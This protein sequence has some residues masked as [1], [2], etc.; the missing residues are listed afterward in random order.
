MR[1]ALLAALAAPALLAA[2]PVPGYFRPDPLPVLHG[3]KL[4][5]VTLPGHGTVVAIAPDA[6]AIAIGGWTPSKEPLTETHW[7]KVYGID[8]KERFTAD[9]QKRA[10]TLRFSDDSGTLTAEMHGLRQ[11]LDARTG[12]S[13]GP[14]AMKEAEKRSEWKGPGS[15]TAKLD[16]R[17]KAVHLIVADGDDIRWTVKNTD[18]D[19]I[20]YS[21]AFSPDGSVLAVRWHT[22]YATGNQSADVS[23]VAG[24]DMA[25]AYAAIHLHDA[26][27]GKLLRKDGCGPGWLYDMRWSADGRLLWV[28]GTEKKVTVYAMPLPKN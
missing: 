10:W 6:Q 25:F 8:G 15:L 23:P 19:R 9:T 18:D 12:K 27:T 17:R 24:P 5:E 7:V 28:A 21:A 11:Q 2:N 26:K 16:V 22:L 3:K 1:L 14:E 4:A 13:A 20:L